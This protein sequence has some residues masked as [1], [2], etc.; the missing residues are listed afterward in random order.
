M[1]EESVIGN[2]ANLT[3]LLLLFMHEHS[4]ILQ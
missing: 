3:L 1:N 4:F 2:D